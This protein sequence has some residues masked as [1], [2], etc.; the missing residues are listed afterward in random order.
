MKAAEFDYV[1]A[2]SLDEVCDLLDETGDHKIIAGGQTLVPLMAMRLARP[3]LLIDIADVEALRFIRVEGDVL[4]IGAATRQVE[5]EHSPLVRERLPLLIKALRWVGHPQTRNRGT[6]GGSIAAADP[7]AEIPLVALALEA[8][9]LARSKGGESEL[10]LTD[11]F[12]G[13]MM[14]AL[15]PEQCLV[16]IRFPLWSGR[17]GCGFQEV[18]ARASDFALVA[19]ATQLVLDAGGICTRIAAALGGVGAAP[20]RVRAPEAL[21]GRRLEPA[22]VDDAL[23]ALGDEIA[24]EDDQHASA[25]YRRRVARTLMARAL[26][27][28]RDEALKRALAPPAAAPDSR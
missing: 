8:R 27:E 15:A 2:T 5:A 24:P 25:D 10:A 14:T 6:V 21:L 28:A 12:R 3:A 1:R 20:V 4:R 23:A 26:I 19:A 17:V 13:P 16:E 9:A 7:S 18:S 22:A 11:F